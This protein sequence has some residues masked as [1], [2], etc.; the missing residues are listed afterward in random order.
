MAK[1]ICGERERA[2]ALEQCL[3]SNRRFPEANTD[4][5]AGLARSVKGRKVLEPDS[6]RGA[7][8]IELARRTVCEADGCISSQIMEPNT[9][10]GP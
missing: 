8:P 7:G 3:Q 9:M 10:T 2:S 6:G 1:E 4:T 5:E